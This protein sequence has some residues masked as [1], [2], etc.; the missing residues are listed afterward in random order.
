MCQ[1]AFDTL[2]QLIVTAP[3][4]AYPQFGD[5][6]FVLETDASQEGLGAALS[7]K[8]DDN[9]LRPVAY[10]SRKLHAAEYA[11]TELKTLGLVWAAKYYRYYHAGHQCVP[12]T[13]HSTCTTL[14]NSKNPSP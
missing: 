8:E 1:K 2:K 12:Y 9:H 13:D 7:Q 3:I 4:L 14:L 10:A 5:K 6:I 11:I